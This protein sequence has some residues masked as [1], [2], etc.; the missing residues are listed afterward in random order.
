MLVYVNRETQR[1]EKAMAELQRLCPKSVERLY[2][3]SR[4]GQTSA[5][6]RAEDQMF[7]AVCCFRQGRGKLKSS[8]GRA[9]EAR[10]NRRGCSC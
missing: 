4:L 6:E 7:S 3:S 10:K 2:E 9:C 8:P 1:K 5:R